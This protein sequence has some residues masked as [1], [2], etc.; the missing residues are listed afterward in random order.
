[1]RLHTITLFLMALVFV[2]DRPAAAA[3]TDDIPEQMVKLM[4]HQGNDVDGNKPDCDKMLD[5]LLKH[6][7]ADAA[8]IKR[9]ID[10]DKGKSPDQKKAEATALKQKYGP[11]LDAA[12]NKMGPLRVCAKLPKMDTWRKKLDP[13]PPK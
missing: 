11:R 7:D 6:A 9:A 8:L 3:P 5:A 2:L 10:S 1:M 4:E 13:G 12:I